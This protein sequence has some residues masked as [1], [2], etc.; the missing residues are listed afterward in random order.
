M[1]WS[2]FRLLA[3]ERAVKWDEWSN[4]ERQDHMM[5]MAEARESA[6][7]WERSEAKAKQESER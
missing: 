7:A 6:M 2:E 3:I 4:A 5:K 1:I